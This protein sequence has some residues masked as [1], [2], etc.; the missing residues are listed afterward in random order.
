M[1]ALLALLLFGATTI[2]AAPG[3]LDPTFGIGGRLIDGG[4]F[5]HDVAVQSDGKIVVVGGHLADLVVA[6]YNPNG[7]PDVTFGFG[8]GKVITDLGRQ[9]YE[10]NIVIQPDGKIVAGGV[11]V[12]NGAASFLIV[13]YNSDGSFDTG[14]GGGTGKVLTALPCGDTDENYGADF[15]IQPDGK[16]VGAVKFEYCPGQLI[17]YISD[18]SLD[19]SFGNHGFVTLANGTS[20][21]TSVFIQPNGKVIWGFEYSGIYRYEPNGSP[22][23]SFGPGG[24]VLGPFPVLGS[25]II[26]PDGKIVAFGWNGNSYALV[27]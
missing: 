8:T 1:L 15:T 26:Q 12:R 19:V 13:R 2:T 11:S 27:R 20:S 3:D 16:F 17:R 18:G 5:A 6:R 7:S 25:V 4:G 9:E 22:D 10:W 14:F 24:H 23:L 21:L